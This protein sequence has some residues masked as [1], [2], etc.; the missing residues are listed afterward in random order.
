MTLGS[1]VVTKSWLHEC[2][3]SAAKRIVM[4]AFMS[5]VF[6]GGCRSTKPCEVASAGDE[7]YLVCAAGAACS[8]WCVIGSL[9]VF[10]NAWFVVCA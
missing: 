6:L 2:A 5:H 7:R 8:F 9:M 4:A 10:C 3:R 1:G